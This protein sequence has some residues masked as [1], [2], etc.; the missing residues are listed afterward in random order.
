VTPTRAG[1]VVW[2]ATP[3]VAVGTRNT[4][5]VAEASDAAMP[6]GRVP[7]NT[8]A[9]EMVPMVKLPKAVPAERAKKSVSE[10]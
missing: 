4:V 9:E 2:K 7:V 5:P 3:P 10:L 8:P 6:V 1:V